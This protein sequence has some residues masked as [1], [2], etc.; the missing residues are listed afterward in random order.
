[1]LLVRGGPRYGKGAFNAELLGTLKR[2]VKHGLVSLSYSKTQATTLGKTGVL[3]TQSLVATLALRIAKRLEL[4]S[5]PGLYRNS[6]RGKNLVALR[7]NVET[8]WHFAPWFHRGASYSFDRQ[9]PDFGAPGRIRRGAFQLR[10]LSSPQQR[11]PEDPLSDAPQ[12]E[13]N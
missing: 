1:M 12:L 13:L 2:R 5:G 4:A 3:D 8:L 9:Q 7:L 10:V 6:L 11:R